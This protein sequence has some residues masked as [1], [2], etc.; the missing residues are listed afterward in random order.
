MEMALRLS[1]ESAEFRTFLPRIVDL[2]DRFIRITPHDELKDKFLHMLLSLYLLEV[3]PFSVTSDED[4][5]KTSGAATGS[6]KSVKRR[7]IECLCSY[8]AGS[9]KRFI[10]PVLESLTNVPDLCSTEDA[11]MFGKILVETTASMTSYNAIIIIQSA[12][13]NMHPMHTTSPPESLDMAGLADG[14][15]RTDSQERMW[16]SSADISLQPDGGVR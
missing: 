8:I 10:L 2:L 16:L 12:V 3:H 15:L 9:D 14:H 7:I 11:K 1:I 6:Q 4:S 13:D 5:D